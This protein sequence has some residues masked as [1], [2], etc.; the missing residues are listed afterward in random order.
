VRTAVFRRFN[1]QIDAV[2]A[3][4]VRVVGPGAT[5]TQA[6]EPEYVALD[7]AARLTYEVLR[8]NNAVT[9]HGRAT[10]EMLRSRSRRHRSCG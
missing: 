2:H 5:V 6:L 8:Q 4:G 7:S 1:E 9:T 3:Q 10:L